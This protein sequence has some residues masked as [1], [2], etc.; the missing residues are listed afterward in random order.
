VVSK[1]FRLAELAAAL[2]QARLAAASAPKERE[3]HSAG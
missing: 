1:P 3:R 2:S